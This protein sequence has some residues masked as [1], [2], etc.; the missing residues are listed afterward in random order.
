M[1]KILKAGMLADRCMPS[2]ACWQGMRCA[3][4]SERGD[5]M[6]G[7]LEAEVLRNGDQNVVVGTALDVALAERH[8][9][10]ERGQA[11]NLPQRVCVLTCAWTCAQ[12]CA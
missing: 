9:F 12:A 6:T 4:T 10:D 11:E 1:A 5:A 2:G 8:V 7:V 3:R